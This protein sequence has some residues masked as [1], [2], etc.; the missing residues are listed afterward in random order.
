MRRCFSFLAAARIVLVA[1]ASMAAGAAAAQSG[2]DGASVV[3][4]EPILDN[5]AALG[6][7]FEIFPAS[8]ILVVDLD[9]I[10]RDSAAGRSIAAAEAAL[11]REIDEELA[12]RRAALEA[13]SAALIAARDGMAPDEFQ[14]REDAFRRDVAALRRF[15]RDRAEAV[16]RGVAE[17]RADLITAVEPILIDIMRERRAAVMLDRRAVVLRADALD[18]TDE[19]ILRLDEQTPSIEVRI[20]ETAGE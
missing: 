17:A 7:E 13:E 14:Q 6:G 20:E 2:D 15:R 12:A 8:A 3:E 1:I 9:R 10:A 4:R 19:A 16:R 18:I 5:D 11:N